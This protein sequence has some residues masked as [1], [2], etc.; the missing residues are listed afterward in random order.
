MS[1]PLRMDE[2]GP[3]VSSRDL[4]VCQMSNEA[5]ADEEVVARARTC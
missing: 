1:R 4:E 2:M 3:G 5:P